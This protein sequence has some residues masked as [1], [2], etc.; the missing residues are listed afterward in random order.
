MSIKVPEK[1]AII[2]RQALADKKTHAEMRALTGLADNSIKVYLSVLKKQAVGAGP[3][4]VAPKADKPS[5]PKRASYI[6]KKTALTPSTPR[7]VDSP[8]TARASA[9]VD[10]VLP[11]E[12]LEKAIFVALLCAP[13]HLAGPEMS[14]HILRNAE[15]SGITP[16][17]ITEAFN[18]GRALLA[19]KDIEL[20]ARFYVSE[21]EGQH[22][23]RFLHRLR[24]R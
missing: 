20:A 9:L 2:L 6:P 15:I 5:K 11:A 1:H 24:R 19:E 3:T 13:D 14:R 21:V 8:D 22:H 7:Q 17:G 12:T 18:R 10:S 4:G 16:R 23:Y